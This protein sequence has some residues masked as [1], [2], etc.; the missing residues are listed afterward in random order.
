M[1][2]RAPLS[3]SSPSSFHSLASI[4]PQWILQLKSR[5]LTVNRISPIYY[6]NFNKNKIDK[7][8]KKEQKKL[9]EIE[10]VVA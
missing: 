6:R 10:I 4:Q 5:N 1:K 9:K 2:R 3:T 8:R 7:T